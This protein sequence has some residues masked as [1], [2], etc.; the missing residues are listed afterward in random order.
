MA[1][2][3]QRNEALVAKQLDMLRKM[4]ELDI[5]AEEILGIYWQGAGGQGG[6]SEVRGVPVE[7]QVSAA[8]LAEQYRAFWGNGAISQGDRRGAA[9]V[10]MGG[11]V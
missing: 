10:I 11:V 7:D 9:Y 5:L 4:R 2:N 6:L 1:F 3:A 8:S